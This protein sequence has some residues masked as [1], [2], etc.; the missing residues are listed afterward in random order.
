MLT[1]FTIISKYFE[2]NKHCTKTGKEIKVK[3][4]LLSKDRNGLDS[5]VYSTLD[6]EVKD[7]NNIDWVDIHMISAGKLE[8]DLPNKKI[9]INREFFSKLANMICYLFNLKEISVELSNIS[10]KHSINEECS[11][12]IWIKE[13]INSY[14]K[15]E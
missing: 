12:I 13:N 2:E 9:Q 6:I 14:I 4:S 8:F 3:E 1:A 10:F 7:R 11:E 5:L 15:Q